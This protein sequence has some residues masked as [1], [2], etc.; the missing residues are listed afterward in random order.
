[1]SGKGGEMRAL[2][3]YLN[4]KKR[5]DAGD[6]KAKAEI[7]K[8]VAN[9][10]AVARLKAIAAQATQAAQLI[11][12]LTVA[13]T[14]VQGNEEEPIGSPDDIYDGDDIELAERV[15]RQLPPG[16]DSLDHKALLRKARASASAAVSQFMNT[17]PPSVFG[18]QLGQIVTVRSDDIAPKAVVNWQGE[19]AHTQPVT[20]TLT[21]VQVLPVNNAA[22]VAAAPYADIVFGTSAF[23]QTVRVDIGRGVQV[24]VSGASVAALVGLDVQSGFAIGMQIAGLLSFGNVSRNTRITRTINLGTIVSILP[25]NNAIPLFARDV[26]LVSADVTSTATVDVLDSA[27]NQLQQIKYASGDYSLRQPMPLASGAASITVTA[28]GTF[29]LIFGMSF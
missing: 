3:A 7:A 20:L 22:A 5:A 6:P 29:N 23:S 11:S 17:N 27:G 16:S 13:P 4:L 24:T 2:Q 26:Q 19:D 8:L 18:A 14:Q 10:T 9:P 15:H 1:M 21:P 25:V 28:N 12:A